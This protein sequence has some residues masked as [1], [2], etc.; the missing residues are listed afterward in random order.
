MGMNIDEKDDAE[1]I[2]SNDTM[3]NTVIDDTLETENSSISITCNDNEKPTNITNNNMEVT[4]SIDYNKQVSDNKLS[5]YIS[6]TNINITRD[7]SVQQQK[8]PREEM[9]DQFSNIGLVFPND[10][11]T[12]EKQRQIKDA[13][14][15]ISEIIRKPLTPVQDTKRLYE[16]ESETNVEEEMHFTTTTTT[17]R[18]IKRKHQSRNHNTRKSI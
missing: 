7:E 1:Y 10:T 15:G 6:T 12:P 9:F 8:Q 14:I 4:P 5:S 16:K 2:I 3:K 13:T 18:T 11:A 17:T